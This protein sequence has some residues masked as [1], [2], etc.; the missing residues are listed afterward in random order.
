MADKYETMFNNE[1]EKLKSEEKPYPNI[2]LLGETGCGKSSLINLVFGKEIAYVNDTKRGTESFD[3]YEGK[4][5]NLGV[6]LID[7]RG[8]ELSDGK[9]DTFDKYYSTIKEKMETSR[10]ADPFKKIHIIWYCVSVTGG[11]FQE[12]DSETLKMLLKDEELKKRVCLVITKCDK[13]DEDGSVSQAIAEAAKDELKYNIPIFC[14]SSNPNLPLDL[15]KLTDWS[16]EQL[17]NDDLREA[18]VQSQIISL[19]AKRTSAG[20]K[21]A[22]YAAAAAAIGASPIPFSDAALL[23]PLQITMTTHIVNSYGLGSIENITKSLIGATLIPMLGKSLAGNIIKLIPA[24]GQILGPVI[25]G[26]V[27]ASITTILGCAIS[28]ICFVCCEKIAKGEKVDFEEAFNSEN[29]KSAVKTFT[30]IVKN[31]K[32]NE[33][34]GTTEADSN[35]VSKFADAYLKEN[36][37]DRG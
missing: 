1:W 10:K 16:M 25:N 19:K 22:F 12:Y 34:I 6:N 35:E 21:I 23:T 18:F 26:A 2:M 9:S 20:V 4:D 13:D 31:K 29:I 36:N 3:T 28:Q 17:D 7:S 15:E 32:N 33:F 24:F 27:A 37:E 5:H 11:R 30:E 8:Y 14:V